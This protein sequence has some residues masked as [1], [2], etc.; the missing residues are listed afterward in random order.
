MSDR[1]RF[2]RERLGA[3]KELSVVAAC[4]A[5][6]VP[7][8]LYYRKARVASESEME[9]ASRIRLVQARIP[10]YGY[11]RLAAAL[12]EP[13]KR[14]R[15]V[16]A[17]QGLLSQSKRKKPRTTLPTYVP[18]NSNL[19]GSS[20]PQL[21]GSVLAADVTCIP[22]GPRYAFLAVVLDLATRELVGWALSWKN[23]LMLAR[24]ALLLAMHE[25]LLKPSWIHHSDRGAPYTSPTYRADV[26]SRGGAM[27]FADVGSPRQ[28]AFVESF[29]KTLKREAINPTTFETFQALELQLSEYSRFYNNERLH[30]SLGMIAP[31]QYRQVLRKEHPDQN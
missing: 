11:R 17:R 24:S 4:R 27:S 20:C 8:S 3:F 29:I 10:S 7:R 13:E 30:S 12:G 25:V 15:G 23:D 6:G 16:M 14:V 1:A 31:F 19:L 28:N 5:V 22:I 18:P 9:L 26:V 2:A 21:P